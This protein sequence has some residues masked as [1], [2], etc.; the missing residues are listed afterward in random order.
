MKKKTAPEY[1]P[2]KTVAIVAIIISLGFHVIMM[3]S[4]FFGNTLFSSEIV[5]LYPH[6]FNIWR[7]LYFT[8][9]SYIKTNISN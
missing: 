8:T 4:F 5:N 9:T 2:M 1:L 6:H 7:F 3:L